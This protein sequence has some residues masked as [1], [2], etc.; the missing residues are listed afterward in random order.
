MQERFVVFK[1]LRH[2][3]LGGVLPESGVPSSYILISLVEFTATRVIKH[4][5]PVDKTKKM[6]NRYGA[7]KNSVKNAKLKTVIHS[8]LQSATCMY[9]KF[10]ITSS[11]YV[12]HGYDYCS[13]Y[14][15]YVIS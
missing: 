3:N 15:Y 10:T 12:L 5:G 1:L 7:F 8:D 6:R 13:I 2:S 11:T 14:R 4:Q 9:K